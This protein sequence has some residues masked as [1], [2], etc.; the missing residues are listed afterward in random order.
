MASSVFAAIAC[1]A[2]LSRVVSLE[3]SIK[4]GHG[5]DQL[6]E[7]TNAALLHVLTAIVDKMVSEAVMK[8]QYKRAAW[9]KRLNE[10]I[11]KLLEEY[12]DNFKK[13]LTHEQQES[14]KVS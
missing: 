5:R 13:D 6:G 7:M 2:I 1:L 10:A 4:N 12:N 14:K 8:E 11:E 3:D 9:F